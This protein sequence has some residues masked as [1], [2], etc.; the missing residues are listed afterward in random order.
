MLSIF[1]RFKS[2]SNSLQTMD[3]ADLDLHLLHL[4]LR[5]YATDGLVSVKKFSCFVDVK[6]VSECLFSIL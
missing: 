4:S 6:I 1:S 2:T 3:S 5:G